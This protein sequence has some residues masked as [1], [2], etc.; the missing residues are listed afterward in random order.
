[1]KLF[2]KIPR[3]LAII[4]FALFLWGIGEGLFLIFQP[5][6]LQH[7]GAQPLEIGAILGG[8]GVAMAIAQAP[9]GYIGDRIGSL[10][11]TWA[12][13]VLGSAAAVI[14]ALANSLPVFVAGMFIYGLTSFVVAPMNSYISSVRER[15]SVERAITI[16]MAAF[17]LGAVGGSLA[18]GVIG[19][20][21]G[22]VRVYQIAAVIFIFSTIVV[23]QADRPPQE[24]QAESHASQPNLLRNPRFIGL[25]VLIFVT[26]FSL[27]LPQPL[28]PNYLQNE[29]HLSLQTIGWLGAVGNLG[30]ALLML[31]LGHLNAAA[32]FMVGQALVGVFAFLMWRGETAA[33]FFVGY[34]LLGGYRLSRSMVLAYARSFVKTSEVG[35]AFGLVETGNAI[36]NIL[37][38]M[39]AG[40]LY[41]RSPQLI[42][43]V[44]LGAIAIVMAVNF[45]LLPR[46]SSPQNA[47]AMSSVGEIDAT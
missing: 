47:P 42:Y 14:M 43:I 1:M 32:G 21:W 45:I 29:R 18:G 38:P 28:T 8:M 30:N 16:S 6:Y 10:P 5:I 46:H 34:F 37:A 13:W 7:W 12:S 39:A 4:S 25:L 33:L 11:V 20:F 40:M 35:L 2:Q 26:M 22:L 44:S 27:L 31:G 17:F 15:L 23:F 9:A 24:E 19:G 3:D 41:T 36:S